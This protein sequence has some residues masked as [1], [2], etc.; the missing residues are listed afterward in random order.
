VKAAI[1]FLTPLGGASTPT[2]KAV[3]WFPL[4]GLLIGTVLGGAWRGAEELWPPA[5][6][7]AL[8]VVLD[9]VLTGMLHVDGLVDSADGLLPHLSKERRLEVMQEPT[10]GAFGVTVVAVTLLLRWSALASMDADIW[11]L[12]GLW[13]LSRTAMVVVMDGLPYAR[14]EGLASAFAGEG[15]FF[16]VPAGALVAAVVVGAAIGWPSMLVV[17]AAWLTVATVALLAS[18]RIGGFTGDVIGAAAVLAETVGL[19]VAAG[20]W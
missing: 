10:V 2:P 11:L 4:V 18:K 1:G 14:T 9:L 15:R 16:V 19:V 8:V 13:C 20:R 5:V 17:L 12:A 3:R 6:A 7:A